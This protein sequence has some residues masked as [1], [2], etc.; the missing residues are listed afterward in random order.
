MNEE[1]KPREWLKQFEGGWYK[2]GAT[3]ENIA[4]QWLENYQDSKYDPGINMIEIGKKRAV[5]EFD[6]GSKSEKNK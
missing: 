3:V 6:T 2:I 4:S 1:Q 5:I